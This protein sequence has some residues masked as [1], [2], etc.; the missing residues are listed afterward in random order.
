MK[1][2]IWMLLTLISGLILYSCKI[3]DGSVDSPVESI[4]ENRVAK[5]T[6]IVV[7]HVTSKPID[8]AIVYIKGLS[9][10]STISG[11]DGSYSFNITLEST[12][13]ITIIAE[14][15]GY[16]PDSTVVNVSPGKSV[17]VTNLRLIQKSGSQIISNQAASI[18]LSFQSTK[19]LGIKSSGDIETAIATFQVID[20]SGVPI[21]ETR[22]V[23]VEFAI[24]A[25]PGG[26]E[27]LYPTSATTNEKG[28]V[29]T[30][31]TTGTKA[32]VMQVEAIIKKGKVTINSKPVF[33]TIYGGFPV[34]EQFA[35]A[36]EKL[37]Y[38]FWS[39]LNSEIVFTAVLGD[40]YSNPVRPNTAV[41]F[42][43]TGGIIGNF[44]YTDVLGR[45]SATLVTIGYPYDPLYGYGHFF[46]TAQTSTEDGKIISTSTH[47]LLSG[48]PII[49]NV[50]PQTFSIKNGGS[51]T[52][53][54]V[55]KD[56]NGNP[57]SSDHTISFVTQ[58]SI[59]SDPSIKVPDSL[60]PGPGITEF[61]FSIG[62]A[63]AD[64]IKPGKASVQINITGP[65]GTTTYTISGTSE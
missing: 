32:G 20:S 56:V 6:G 53:S 1:T 39:I 34:Q 49:S 41:Y 37:N 51:E 25:G 31:I 19:K 14:K 3:K 15:N 64:E 17:T 58:G 63:A 26:G 48:A 46:V 33:F 12:Q 57:I 52:F 13:N 59:S 36:C 62:D 43:T 10:S 47:R 65:F 5:I 60:F 21:D 54:F 50:S 45:A 38:P 29:T 61:T 40:K 2:K 22:S 23:N 11:S 30:A 18:Y 24:I 7:D 42:N 44:I 4:N 28:Q 8:N 27:F 55:V 35:V 9:S 16:Q